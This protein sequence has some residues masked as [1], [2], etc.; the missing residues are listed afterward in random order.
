MFLTGP[1]ENTDASVTETTVPGGWMEESL[2]LAGRQFELVRP[3]Q[4]D[5]FL[6]A[7]AELPRE[8]H[9]RHDVYWA[10]LWQAA[11]ATAERILRASWTPGAEALEFGCGL[12]L[13]GLA[14]LA[15]GLDVTFSDYE[16]M[17]VETALE[18][19][20]R[21]G[22]TSAR[23]EIIDWRSPPDKHYRYVLG[24]DV[25]YNMEMHEPLVGFLDA[26]LADDGLCWIGDAGR[27]HADKF[28][29]LAIARGFKVRLEDEA[30]QELSAARHGKFQMF[31]ITRKKSR[32]T[33]AKH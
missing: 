24:S 6:E 33:A 11:P 10:A 12:G 13:V 5:A 21:N 2:T 4:P 1:R 26:V 3:Q 32:R 25:L 15:S 9:D 8:E 18:N 16:S 19:A 28:R 27:F 7:L 23:G 22:F 14:A 17:A 20:R 30:G 29:K 31:V